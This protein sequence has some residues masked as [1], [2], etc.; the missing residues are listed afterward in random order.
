MDAYKKYILDTIKILAEDLNKTN[1]V[2]EKEVDEMLD[3]ERQLANITIREEDR[4]NYTALY[5]PRTINQL[6]KLLP[7]VSNI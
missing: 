4:R 5:N 1:V 6:H 2:Y 3:F 7:F